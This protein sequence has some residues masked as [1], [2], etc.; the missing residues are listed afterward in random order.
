MIAHRHAN[1]WKQVGADVVAVAALDKEVL[2]ACADK[3]G[4]E[5]R[6]AD[7]HAILEAG[8]AGSVDSCTPQHLLASR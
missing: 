7:D 6:Q 3:H 1:R 4:M 8:A 2:Q 5:R